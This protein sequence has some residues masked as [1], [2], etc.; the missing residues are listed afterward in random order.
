MTRPEPG[1]L[2][3]YLEPS[4]ALAAVSGPSSLPCCLHDYGRKPT[5]LKVSLVDIIAG[6]FLHS[7]GD[8]GVPLS[9]P[10]LKTI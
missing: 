8:P 5:G 10:A 2:V 7:T 3:K 6:I 1:W 4:R 9:V